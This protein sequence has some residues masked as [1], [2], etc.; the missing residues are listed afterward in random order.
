MPQH[1]LV[2]VDYSEQSERALRQALED[3]PEATISVL[4]VVDFRS[5]DLGP[6]GFGT[7][8]AWE[9]WSE[10]AR[11]H[12]DELLETVR[13]IAGEYDH[14]VR[15]EAV[16]GEDTSTI[17]DYV[18]EHDVDHVYIGSHGRSGASR[19]LLGSVAETV[20]RRAPVPVTV[21]R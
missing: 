17:L 14:E 16:F 4:H 20:V 5:S 12:A 10:S 21:V 1:I 15:T 2:P 3:F 19:I 13:S 9:A 18:D 8:N 11:E 7:V 6:G